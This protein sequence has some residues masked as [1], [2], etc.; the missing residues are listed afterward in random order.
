MRIITSRDLG[1]VV[2]ARRGELG[3]TQATLADRTGVSREW[4]RQLEAGKAT[5]EL[6]LALRTLRALGLNIEVISG[7]EAE[8]G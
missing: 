4:L 8:R 6:G 5:V 7:T 1:A 3:L 2:R